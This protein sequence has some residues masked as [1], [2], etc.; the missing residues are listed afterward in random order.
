MPGR[1]REVDRG[2]VQREVPRRGLR[3]PPTRGDD[4][5]VETCTARSPAP[6]GSFIVTPLGLWQY[7]ATPALVAKFEALDEDGR[8][9]A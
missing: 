4:P 9:R 6:E 1:G 7:T 5:P 3:L 2:Q 8:R